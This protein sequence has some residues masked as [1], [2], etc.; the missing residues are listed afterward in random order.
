MT[1]LD[2][3]PLPAR[4]A[5]QIPLAPLAAALALLLVM[6]VPALLAPPATL[7]PGDWHGNAAPSLVTRR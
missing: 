4:R 2:T 3:T 5:A 6:G 1:C 7:N